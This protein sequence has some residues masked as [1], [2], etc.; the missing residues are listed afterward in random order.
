MHDARKTEAHNEARRDNAAF[1]NTFEFADTPIGLQ[2]AGFR[3]MRF[4]ERGYNY[5]TRYPNF[6]SWLCALVTSCIAFFSEFPLP[7]FSVSDDHIAFPPSLR[8]RIFIR[9]S[10]PLN[11][12]IPRHIM[13]SRTRQIESEN[14][15][16]SRI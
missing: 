4:C 10:L 1:L 8:Y 14:P 13:E 12:N 11:F 9:T 15:Y 3:H 2:S 6:F 7:F 5:L 16:S